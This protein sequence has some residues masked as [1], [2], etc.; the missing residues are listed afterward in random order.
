[1]VELHSPNLYLSFDYENYNDG[2]Y[3]CNA[4]IFLICMVYQLYTLIFFKIG[5]T[6]VFLL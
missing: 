5:K 2:S 1:M 4:I 6:D 3:G